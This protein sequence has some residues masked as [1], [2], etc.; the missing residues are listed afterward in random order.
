MMLRRPTDGG[1]VLV[2]CLFVWVR[3][4]VLKI[5]Y[6]NWFWCDLL[7][8]GDGQGNNWWWYIV[9]LW[10]ILL[11]KILKQSHILLAFC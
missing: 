6:Q 10:T 1:Y 9:I 2:A 5:Y 11:R 4:Y 8:V 7:A 3:D